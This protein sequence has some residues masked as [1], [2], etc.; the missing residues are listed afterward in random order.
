[1]LLCDTADHDDGT[2]ISCPLVMYSGRAF[3]GEDT[4]PLGNFQAMFAWRPN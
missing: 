4:T 2:G 3:K 1:M